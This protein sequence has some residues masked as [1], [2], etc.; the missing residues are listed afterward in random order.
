MSIKSR[1][2]PLSFFTL[3]FCLGAFG[4]FQ[5][6]SPGNKAAKVNLLKFSVDD[7]VAGQPAPQ[8]RSYVVLQLE[9]ENAHPKQKVKK[10]DLEGKQ[11]RTMGAAQLREGKKEERKEEYVDKDVPYVI[12]N[13]FDHAYLLADGQTYP[14]DKLTEKV[15][16][17]YALNKEFSILK[18]GDRKNVQFVFLVPREAG[19]LAFQ[20]FDYSYG[21]I[22]VPVKGDLKLAAG[23]DAP[24]VGVLDEIKDSMVEIAARS[25]SFRDEYKD[26]GAPEGWRYAVAGISGKSLAGSRAMGNIIQLQPEENIWVS[27]P[28]GHLYYS[29]GGST[30]EDGFIRF[31][32]EFSQTQEIA[33]LVPSSAEDYALG[34]RLQNRVYTLKLDPKFQPATGEPLAKH[35][36]G[37]TMEVFL[38]GIEKDGENIILDLGIKSLVGSGLEIQTD[39]QF[40]LKGGEEDLY[41][42]ETAT[43]ALP[44]RPPTPFVI[45]PGTF[46]R[47]ELAYA[48][49]G[50]PTILYYRGYKSE[51][52]LALPALKSGAER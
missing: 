15:P 36:D 2:V 37:K 33:F 3:G 17:G 35:L 29:C 24:A 38:Y 16:G 23:K 43:H 6:E 45:P 51:G 4:A 7:E 40:I 22:L 41:P 50:I 46:V 21:H 31:T 27:T 18:L 20:F 12:P 25:F 1:L 34:I 49:K 26:E 44:H 42:E 9:W 52:K 11:D 32:P 13:F 48:A 10:S 47:F 8:G 39:Q 30:T 5:E 19:N 14:L 28:E